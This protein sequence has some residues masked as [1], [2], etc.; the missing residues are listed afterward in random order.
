MLRENGRALPSAVV[1][2]RAGPARVELARIEK[3]LGLRDEE[4]RGCRRRPCLGRTYAPGR[5]RAQDLTVEEELG[6]E[7]PA[8][9]CEARGR[10]LPPRGGMA[11]EASDDGDD[12]LAGGEGSVE[13]VLVVGETPR[14]VSDGTRAPLVSVDEEAVVGV[15]RDAQER[16][17]RRHGKSQGP[18]EEHARVE[19]FGR[20]RTVGMR[21]SRACEGGAGR[22]DPARRPLLRPLRRRHELIFTN[23]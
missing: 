9:Q 1:I 3:L 4:S 13:N 15:R 2:T 18:A 21:P 14:R 11:A 16:L 6:G 5:V 10:G 7:A 22:P 23:W 8:P 12:V 17:G 19:E 20:G